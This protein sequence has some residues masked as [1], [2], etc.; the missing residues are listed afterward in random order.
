VGIAAGGFASRVATGTVK[1]FLVK[2]GAEAAVK[3]AFR[4]TMD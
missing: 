1:Q 2:K 3:K 4:E